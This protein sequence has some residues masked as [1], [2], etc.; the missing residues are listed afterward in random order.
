MG[1]R[2]RGSGVIP[3]NLSP[4][5]GAFSKRLS[6]SLH[7]RISKQE[8][9]AIKV[10]CKLSGRAIS[11]VDQQLDPPSAQPISEPCIARSW[12]AIQSNRLL[13]RRDSPGGRLSIRRRFPRCRMSEMGGV[14][15]GIKLLEFCLGT[16][17]VLVT[18]SVPPETLEKLETHGYHFWTLPAPFSHEELHTV[19]FDDA[20]GEVLK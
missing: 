3:Q 16:K 5:N 10:T 18:E 8:G 20:Q 9:R 15:A 13:V 1:G 6:E 17:I 4:D 12:S 11:C 2:L 7:R 19:M 14:E